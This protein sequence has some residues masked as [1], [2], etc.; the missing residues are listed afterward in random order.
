MMKKK[1]RQYLYWPVRLRKPPRRVKRLIR[2]G[3][4]SSLL[5]LNSSEN[6]EL[7]AQYIE[8]LNTHPAEQ[9]AS[10]PVDE[11]IFKDIALIHDQ[12]QQNPPKKAV[13]SEPYAIVV[14]GGGNA[15][16]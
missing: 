13:Q 2:R 9:P 10:E 15:G 7:M 14:L 4:S 11:E 12:N 3:K 5:E 1:G 6:K 16:R 8:F